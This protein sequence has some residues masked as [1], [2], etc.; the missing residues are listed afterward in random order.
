[1]ATIFSR[2][3]GALSDLPSLPRL[4]RIAHG[5]ETVEDRS[6][7]A[8][9]L[10]QYL[11]AADDDLRLEDALDLSTPPHSP[12]WWRIDAQQRRDMWIKELARAYAPQPSLAARAEAVELMLKRYAASQW[13]TDRHLTVLPTET[14]ETPRQLM[15]YAFEADDAVPSARQLRRILAGK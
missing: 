10:R 12:P 7:L 4:R 11:S 8:A 13:Q 15:F 3:I 9:A 5:V 6:W 2:F 1:M 14:H